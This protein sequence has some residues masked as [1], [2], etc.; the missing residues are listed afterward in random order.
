MILET[1]KFRVLEIRFEQTFDGTAPA[2]A[3]VESSYVNSGASVAV[4]LGEMPGIITRIEAAVR[5]GLARILDRDQERMIA[6]AG[7][8]A[9]R[10]KALRDG[11]K[12]TEVAS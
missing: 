1:P 9:A 8:T 7:E 3:I 5:E 4:P 2:Y 6:I 11:I 10:A 12:T